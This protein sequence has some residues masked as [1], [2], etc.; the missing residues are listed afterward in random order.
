[1][2][3]EQSFG[4]KAVETMREADESLNMEMENS[5]SFSISEAEKK[6]N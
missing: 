1:M 3:E 6:L 4:F 2:S 5:Q